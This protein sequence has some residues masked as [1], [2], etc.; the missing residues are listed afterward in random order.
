MGLLVRG[1]RVVRAVRGVPGEGA[2]MTR[3]G[4]YRHATGSARVNV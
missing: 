2:R 3:S 4:R 1:V